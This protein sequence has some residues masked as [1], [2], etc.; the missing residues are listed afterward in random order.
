[1]AVID[2]R[3][4]GGIA[5][6]VDPRELGP[7][8]AQ[9]ASN[10]E[11]RYGDFRPIKGPGSSVATVTSGAQTIH[12]TPSGTWLHATGD[13]D[14]VN[15]QINDTTDERVYLT[16]RS[17]YPEAWGGSYRRLGV[18]APT[19]APTV[20]LNAQD[21]F[22]TTERGTAV[23][24][25]VQAIR[26]AVLANIDAV[27][28]ANPKPTTTSLDSVW[29]AHGDVLAVGL[30]TTSGGQIAYAVP[31]TGS[32]ATN[33][34]D[35]YLLDPL[36]H[37]AEI[38]YDGDP[39]WAVPAVWRPY[40]YDVDEAAISTAIKALTKPPENV[41]QLVPDAIADQIAARIAKIADETADPLAILIAN[42]NVAQGDILTA[43]LRV[44][45]N[46][47]RVYALSALISRLEVA[48]RAVDNYFLN[49]ETQLSLI[50]TEYEY[51]IPTAVARVLETRSYLYT[52]VTDWGEES[53][54][55][56]AS[57]LLELDQNDFVDITVAAPPTAGV[58]GAITAWRL[59][60]SST[61][62]QGTA[63]EFV[64]E[65]LVAD[66]TYTD[67]KLQEELGPDVCQTLTWTEPREDMVGLCGGANGIMLGYVGKILC[68][69]EPY[70]PYAWPREYEHALQYNIVAIGWTGQAWVVVT[71]G[72]TYLVSGADS[73]QLSEQKLDRS[74]ACV[75][76][77]SLKSVAGG[78]LFASPDGICLADPSGVT[79]LT[80]G[81][82]DKDDW[83][84]LT[85][86]ASFA[87]FSEGVYHLWLTTAGQRLALDFA[88]TSM[89]LTAATGASGAYTDMSTDT[90]YT[91]VGTT[92]LPMFA[93]SAQTGTWESGIY[94]FNGQPSFA[95]ARV[96]GDFT[97]GTLTIY[98]DGATVLATTV[99]ANTPIR[100]PDTRGREWSVKWVD[101]ERATRITLASSSA[102]L[103]GSGN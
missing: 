43:N 94:T 36:L 58:Y 57:D 1:V 34:T 95:W 74:Q 22:D 49:W 10:V 9:T 47:T 45:D 63:Y 50:L 17:A 52:Y 100:L 42:V 85:P 27:P 69:C 41:D 48:V 66:L 5:P 77:R 87:A 3:S 26:D 61:T 90:M 8:R 32:A 37:G 13:A 12:R 89:T 59:Y 99:S 7:E 88:R 86:S 38:T 98:A 73:A 70:T 6:S 72:D 35:Q 65:Q 75:S 4:F 19:A 76:K 102:E 23:S 11:L 25:A 30:P 62:N 15:G 33:T 20:A 97:S 56:P 39:Y 51:L 103:A 64:V 29:I 21:E 40:G 101:T 71:E 96:N 84:G 14:Y 54:P 55:S 79:L 67:E 44:L 31:L 93:G 16:G 91:V 53:A 46:T 2:I 24:N 81:A 78:V 60:R 82:Y 80:L 18:R 68:A 92:V 83:T 28:I